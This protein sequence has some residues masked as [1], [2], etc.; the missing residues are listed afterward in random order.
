MPYRKP[1]S[2]PEPTCSDVIECAMTN[3]DPV[4]VAL[5]VAAAGIVLLFL[6]LALSHIKGARSLLDAERE[7]IADEAEAFATFASRVTEID[8][9]AEPVTDGGPAR[10]LALDAPPPPDDGIEAVKDAYRDTVMA[11]PHYEEEYDES[12]ATNM[13]MEFGD[14]VSEAVDDGGPLSPQL[15]RTLVE[16]SRTAQRQRRALRAQLDGESEALDDA[17]TTLR[18]CRQSADRIEEA[19]LEDCSFDELAAEWR[20]LEDRR[21]AAE[22]LLEDRQ[23][24][25]QHR[26]REAGVR[27]GGPSFEEYLYDPLETTYPI[28]SEAT[29]LVDRL[30]DARR[31]VERTLATRA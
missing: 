1:I 15:K 7:R 22:A 24:T 8:V 12:L 28:L 30:E 25:I 6:V 9:A 2:P 31:R 11:V 14:D 17:R 3:P 4:Q 19:S 13:R 29:N 23:E 18:H 21:R 10:T 26:D 5:L 27:P 20:L 16:R